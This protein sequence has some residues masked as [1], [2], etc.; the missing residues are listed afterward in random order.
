MDQ[1]AVKVK[2]GKINWDEAPLPDNDGNPPQNHR[3]ARI[4]RW[5][6][7]ATEIIGLAGKK[8]LV[9]GWS[10]WHGTREYMER[11]EKAGHNFGMLSR[12]YPVIDIDVTLSG[13]ATIARDL[14]LEMLG[15][16]PV[17]SRAKS[18]K[19]LLMY[20]TDDE[21]LRKRRFVFKDQQGTEHAVELLATGQQFVCDGVHPEGMSYEWDEPSFT[22]DD[23]T[24]ITGARW[25]AYCVA[26]AKELKR[27]AG[28]T[29]VKDGLG[30]AM[31]STALRRD[32]ESLLA[33]EP[34][35]ALQAVREWKERRGDAHNEHMGHNEFVELCAAFH[36][37]TGGDAEALYDEFC[38]LLPGDR[39]TDGNT[40]KTFHSMDA[41]NLGWSRLCQITGFIPPDTFDEPPNEADVAAMNAA[42]ENPPDDVSENALAIRFAD[43][44]SENVRY[45]AKEG[46]WL[47]WDGSRWRPDERLHMMTLAREFCR[48]I[49]RGGNQR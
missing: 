45:V 38:E 37:A 24:V 12:K 11:L 21:L 6:P 15:P 42:I 17:R 30:G 27:V 25:D 36:G 20:R 13:L 40:Y 31:L 28:V 29:V 46:Q 49:A 23:L 43:L 5:L 1:I 39:P 41:V 14:A 3:E 34:E 22:P 7:F 16:A 2:P 35:M 19:C 10:T 18:S 32:A 8:P 47:E 4:A 33:P 9:K 44:H 26:L 48:R